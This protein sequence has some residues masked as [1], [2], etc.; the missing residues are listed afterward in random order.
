VAED[1]LEPLVTQCPTCKT[2]FRVTQSQLSMAGGRVRCGACLGVF[3]GSE[4]LVLSS[5]PRLRPGESADAALDALLD[6][7]R[8]DSAVRP[9]ATPNYSTKGKQSPQTAPYGDP[10]AQPA[11]PSDAESEADAA[12]DPMPPVAESA[13]ESALRDEPAARDQIVRY[14][15]PDSADDDGNRDRSDTP[16]DRA[17]ADVMPRR[18]VR[19]TFDLGVDPEE[20][21][22][23]PT[24][25]RRRRWVVWPMLLLCVFVLAAQVMYLQFDVWSKNLEIRPVYSW[26][27]ARIGC[28]LPELRALDRLVSKNLVVRANPEVP[29]ALLVD[30]LIINEAPFAQPFPVIEVRFSSMGGNLIAGRRFRPDEYLA[31]ELRGAKQMTP[32]TPVHISLDIDDPGQDAV[33]YVMVF[34]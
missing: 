24:R 2:R 12:A 17:P 4:N 28:R 32:M 20:L 3:T 10:A 14:P 11:L 5:V 23:A 34:R 22:A 27:C 16:M 1:Q 33:N 15:S 13:A 19:A 30:A 31:G 8:D 6:E 26:V 9:L 7:L 29:G 25:R 18:P 21:V